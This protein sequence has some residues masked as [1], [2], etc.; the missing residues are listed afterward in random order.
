[1]FTVD[2]SGNLYVSL[3]DGILKISKDKKRTLIIHKA[4]KG[5]LRFFSNTLYILDSDHY[6]LDL[7]APL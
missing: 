2:I 6:K 5:K 7:V 4:I 3:D 1:G